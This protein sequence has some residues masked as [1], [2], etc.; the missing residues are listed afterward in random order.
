MWLTRRL[1]E[2][3]IP[4]ATSLWR[5][6]QGSRY[7]LQGKG[8]VGEC[9][10]EQD[11]RDC[12]SIEVFGDLVR[13]EPVTDTFHPIE[14]RPCS[15]N[16]NGIDEAV[17]GADPTGRISLRPSEQWIDSSPLPGADRS[18]DQFKPCGNKKSGQVHH[19]RAADYQ[20]DQKY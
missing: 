8:H 7:S 10:T 19:R 1:T 15:P 17:P 16:C 14:R 13:P 2:A 9:F 11:L 18:A 6:V 20:P 4:W 5:H 12:R 3:S